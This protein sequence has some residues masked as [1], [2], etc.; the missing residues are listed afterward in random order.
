MKTAG[1]TTFGRLK[2]MQLH[3]LGNFVGHKRIDQVNDVK[4][5]YVFSSLEGG[6]FPISKDKSHSRLG[7]YSAPKIT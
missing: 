6:E 5:S 7:H 4:K 2:S 1:H 3:N